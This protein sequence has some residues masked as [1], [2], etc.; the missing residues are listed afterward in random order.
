MSAA[1]PTQFAETPGRRAAAEIIATL[2]NAGHIAYLAGGCVRDELLGRVPQDYD[3]ATDAT[4]PVLTKLFRK[5]SEVGASFGV[6]LVK[7]HGVVTEVA[8]FRAD[9]TYTDK[10]RPDEVRFSTPEDDAARRDFTVNALFLDPADTSAG[11][12]GR[13]IDFVGGLADLEKRVLRAVGDPEARLAEDH[14]RALRAVRLSAKLGFEIDGA[15][16]AAITRHARDLA[17]V[18][19]ERIG[20][21]VRAMMSHPSRT[22][23]VTTLDELELDAPVLR[24]PHQTSPPRTLARLRPEASFGACLSAWALDRGLDVGTTDAHLLVSRWRI[25]LCLSNDE[26]TS[27]SNIL[28]TIPTIERAWTDLGTA[29]RKRLASASVFSDALD[30]VSVRNSGHADRVLDDVEVLRATTSGLSPRPL[31]SGD[32]L[33]G[34]GLS[35][36]P[37]FKVLLDALYDAQLE[38]RIASREAALAL[39]LE[40]AGS[41]GV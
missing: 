10:R 3:V 13:I 18:S 12:H 24:E 32:D 34:L 1:I 29:A 28:Q 40:L 36:G 23:A 37:G 6:V 7:V 26:R 19:R 38:D 21:E 16:R 15:T 22:G 33:I 41:R 4:P 17:G 27:L 20:D 31:I 9:G 25:A 5:T 35:P 30:L 8:T 14:L 2:R 11:P 39:A